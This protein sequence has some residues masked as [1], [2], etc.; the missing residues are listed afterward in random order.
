MFI[1]LFKSHHCKYF[2]V[3]L[4]MFVKMKKRRINISAILYM[5]NVHYSTLNL[6]RS[7]DKLVRAL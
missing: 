6:F 7:P 5:K 1:Y 4:F 2:R 3:L